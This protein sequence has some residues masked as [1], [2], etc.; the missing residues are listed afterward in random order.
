MTETET[1]RSGDRVPRSRLERRSWYE[2]RG[3]RPVVRWEAFQRRLP[4]RGASC[5]TGCARRPD[6][7][8]AIVSGALSGLVVLDVDPRHGGIASLA[9]WERE[10]GALPLT[11][12][13][14]TGGGRTPPLLHPPGR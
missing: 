5:A 8:V 10:H 2:P 9:R 6:A 1:E 11:V 3:K 12:E 7:N 13:A 4:Q 14:Q